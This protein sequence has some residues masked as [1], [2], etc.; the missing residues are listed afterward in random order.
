MTAPLDADRDVVVRVPAFGLTP[1]LGQEMAEVSCGALPQALGPRL[2]QVQALVQ[3]FPMLTHGSYVLLR[4]GGIRVDSRGPL[5][6]ASGH[7][8]IEHRAWYPTVRV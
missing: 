5:G 7:V 3:N 2:L 8:H 4:L 6:A 1:A